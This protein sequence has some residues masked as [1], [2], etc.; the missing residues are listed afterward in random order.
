MGPFVPDIISDELNLV[1]GFLI[2]IAFGFILE[3][4]GFSSSQKLTG[5][6]YGRDFTVLRVFFTA[7]ITAMIGILLLAYFGLLDVDVIYINPTYL[8][9]AL[10]GGAIMGLGFIVGGYCPG[11]SVCGAAIGK[12]DAMVFVLGGMLGVFLFGEMFPYVEKI[13][14]GMYLGDIT[15]PATLGLSPG[16]F[17]L[18]MIVVAVAA[19]IVTTKIEQRVSPA[20][21]SKTFPVR[22]HRF[23]GVGVIVLGVLLLSLPDRKSNLLAKVSDERFL[24]SVSVGNMT[25]DELAFRLLDHDWKIEIIDV[26]DAASYAKLT[27][28]GAVN[29][30]LEEM[31]GK[32]WRDVL[33][34]DKI[35]VF[36]AD[37]ET[38][39]RKAAALA[40]LLGYKN[41]HFL[42]GGLNE[43]RNTILAV[44]SLPPNPSA[45]D[46]DTYRF[47]RSA[48]E[49]ITEMIKEQAA[50]P[51]KVIK[52]VKKVS[53]GC[54]T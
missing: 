52:I 27:L 1:F 9:A 34:N 18:L 11:T 46:L 39:E 32:Q 42:R 12:I 43:F 2:G 41:V 7:A 24:Q 5:L 17:A 51:K 35:K 45:D 47:R 23:A 31:F 38:L 13:Y 14:N 15:V 10:L 30:P 8:W 20:P 44:P 6:F 36:I 21:V 40:Q 19:F 4:A 54:G 48:S 37:D 53:G 29:I 22:Y 25:S 33:T 26:R 28:P 3:Q 16:M 49:P 50:G